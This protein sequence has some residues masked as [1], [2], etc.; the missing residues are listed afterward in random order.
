MNELRKSFA[1]LKACDFFQ[2]EQTANAA[3]S[4]VTECGCHPEEPQATKDPHSLDFTMLGELQIPR[5]RSG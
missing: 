5:C 1:P 3:K 2:L 4:A